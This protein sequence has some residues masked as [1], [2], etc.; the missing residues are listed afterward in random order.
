M[1]ENGR[2][3][4]FWQIV[5][6]SLVEEIYVISQNTDKFITAFD[7]DS[8]ANVTF[9]IVLLSDAVSRL[10]EYDPEFEP[11]ANAVEALSPLNAISVDQLKSQLEE[12]KEKI[13]EARANL[14]K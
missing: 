11:V 10:A 5:A 2:I 3:N 7:D 6:S 12:A 8:A 13:S 14:L 9:R 4:Y 1:N